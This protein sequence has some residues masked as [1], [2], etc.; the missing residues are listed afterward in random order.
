MSYQPYNEDVN[1]LLRIHREI[2]DKFPTN[3]WSKI[4]DAYNENYNRP[5][6]F[7][8]LYNK[9]LSIDPLGLR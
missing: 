9:Y 1:R 4:V 7:N 2:T 6:A 3:F 5:G 8:S